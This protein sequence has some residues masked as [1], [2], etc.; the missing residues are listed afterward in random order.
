MLPL[1]KRMAA[2]SEGFVAAG[3]PPPL[4]PRFRTSSREV[5]PSPKEGPT[6]IFTRT[7]GP[8]RPRRT[9]AAWAF[10]T[11]TKASGFASPRQP[12]I[13]ATPIPGSTTT[14]TAPAR[15]SPNIRG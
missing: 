5:P 3:S 12:F 4:A 10:A 11:P 9:R 8:A 15:K 6:P 14:G 2:G 13:R 7:D 1:V